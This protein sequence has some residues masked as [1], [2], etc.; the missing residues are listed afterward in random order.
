MAE[1]RG[2]ALQVSS[3]QRRFAE[4]ATHLDG[5]RLEAINA[6]GKHLFLAFGG[7]K[8]VHVHLGMQAKRFRYP[9]PTTAPM[10]QVRLRMASGSVAWD[11]IAPSTCELLDDTA[12][13]RIRDGLGPDPLRPDADVSVVMSALA[14]DPRAVGAVLLDQAVLSGVGNVFRNEALH[15]VGLDPHRPSRTLSA[16][17]HLE[18]WRVLERMMRQAVEDGR[19]VTVDGPDRLTVPESEARRVYKQSHCRDCA[20]PVA[21]GTVG[22]RTAYWCP[23]DQPA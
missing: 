10:K 12:V 16:E 19:I 18:L 22:G 8:H 13:R 17:Q 1:L 9:D 6:V 21:T 5:E 2:A 11:L 7:G 4:E 20:A 14:S 15:A 23:V 3:P